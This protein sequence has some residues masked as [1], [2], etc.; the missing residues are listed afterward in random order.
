M[1]QLGT[2]RNYYGAQIP[3]GEGDQG[4]LL[5]D[6]PWAVDMS[7]DATNSMQQGRHAAAKRSVAT[8]AVAACLSYV[9]FSNG[10]R[11]GQ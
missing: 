2:I 3:S 5:P 7:P 6:T 1:A 9:H 10:G 8:V 11:Q 4:T